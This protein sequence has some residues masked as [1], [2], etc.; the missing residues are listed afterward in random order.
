ELRVLECRACG[1]RRINTQIYH[2]LPYLSHLDLGNNQMQFI[3]SDE[4][5]DLRRLHSLKLDGNQLP[6]VLEKTFVRQQEL[7]YLC[8]ARNRLAKITNTAFLNLT[9]L[10]DLDIGYNKLDRMEMVALQHVA[11]T[12]QR[13]VISGNAFGVN[14]IKNILQTVHNVHDLEIA[15]M[16]LRSIPKGFI[17]D[18]IR[19]LNISRN[20]LTEISVESLPKQLLEL[21][22][23][24]NKL[25]EL[26]ERLIFRL[27][28]MRHVSLTGNVWSCTVC[29]LGTAL[30]RVNRS[31]LFRNLTCASPR[32][33]R[34][35]SFSSLRLEE[36]TGCKNLED[37]DEDASLSDNKLSLAVGITSLIV[38]LIVCIIFVVCSCMRRRA[39]NSMQEQKRLAERREN[40]LDN[41]T[42]IFAKGEISFKFPLDLTERKV[43][44]STIDEIK[45]DTQTL[46]N[47]TGI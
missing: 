30:L 14:V 25:T 8:L 21:D 2:L 45:K 5:R 7:K 24:Y 10:T 29:H 47:G 22:L 36:L 32:Y 17:P 4:F 19:K 9:S 38:F 35:R 28:D 18:R 11:D 42:A 16:K 15:K 39:R 43:S 44:V 20:N 1:L 23:S 13:L 33:L 34:G 41:P 31:S 26:D 37:D 3:A 27:E 40:S 12:L 46:P 6:V